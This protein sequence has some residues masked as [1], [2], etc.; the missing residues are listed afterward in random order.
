MIVEELHHNIYSRIDELPT[1]SVVVPRLL[2][3]LEDADVDAG[4]LA[5]LISRDPSLAA[6]VL[7]AANSAY[8]GFSAQ[9]DSLRHAVPLIG[10]NMTKSLAL[11]I[12]VLQ[13][14]P[15]VERRTCFSEEGLWSHSIGVGMLMMEMA[16]RHPEGAG[17]DYLFVIGLLHDVGK[18]VLYHFF[19]EQFDEVLADVAENKGLKLHEVEAREIGTDHSSVAGMLF[20]RWRFP[21]NI[22][23]PIAAM[24]NPEPEHGTNLRDLALLRVANSISQKLRLGEEGNTVPN[25]LKR[26]DLELLKMGEGELK[27]MLE[28][29]DSIRDE[30]EGFLSAVS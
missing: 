23:G 10:L 22:V 9:I 29:G 14:L 19:S 30:V 24:H 27:A 28:Y 1:L 2:Q 25:T 8:Y 6:K 17:G 7:K 15:S 13:A 3:A 21:A 11:S 4:K 20:T 26:A 16:K 5:E 12:G 18:V